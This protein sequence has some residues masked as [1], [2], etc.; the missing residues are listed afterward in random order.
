MIDARRSRSTSAEA[1]RSHPSMDVCDT[2]SKTW[3]VSTCCLIGCKLT[4]RVNSSWFTSLLDWSIEVSTLHWT[5]T[6]GYLMVIEGSLSCKAITVSGSL[7]WR[8]I[9]ICGYAI[10]VR[11]LEIFAIWW[12]LSW[13]YIFAW[14]KSFHFNSNHLIV[15]SP[16][17]LQPTDAETS[18][19]YFRVMLGR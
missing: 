9:P 8:F 14:K 1:N 16:V 6:Q 11:P 15:A 12:T 4:L 13:C 3:L 18:L 17:K 7:N 5:Y 2:S 10:S 19:V